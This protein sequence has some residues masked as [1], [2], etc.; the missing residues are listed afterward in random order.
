MLFPVRCFTC[1]KV[2]GHLHKTYN[3]LLEE[4]MSRKDSLDK[5]G[6]VRYC[7]RRM[8]LTYIDTF[9]YISEFNKQNYFFIHENI[10]E[11]KDVQSVSVIDGHNS[12]CDLGDMDDVE[13]VL[14]TG[15][16]RI[17]DDVDIENN[18]DDDE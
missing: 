3:V 7:C 16:G 18:N 6:A 17:V 14:Q 1:G 2:I 15:M 10:K 13:D 12:D 8:F 9:K 11:V 5:I 4:G